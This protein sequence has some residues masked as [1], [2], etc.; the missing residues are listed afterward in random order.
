VSGPVP[1]VLD[2]LISHDR[3]DNTSDPSINGHLHYPNDL[4][5]PPSETDDDKIRSYRVDYNNRPSNPISFIP[6]INNRFTDETTVLRINLN[7][8]GETIASQSHTHPSHSE[9]SRLLTSS[10]FLGVPVHR[11]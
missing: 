9:T 2:L 6:V 3:F 8:D 1:L 7:I 10:L 5:R 11:G 4:D